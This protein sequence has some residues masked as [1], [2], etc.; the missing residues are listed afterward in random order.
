MI[1]IATIA[2]AIEREREGALPGRAHLVDAAWHTLMWLISREH[3]G[4][5][6]KKNGG[7][8]PTISIRR[9]AAILVRC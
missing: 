9:R 1:S 3:A 5:P 6:K 8:T 2:E 4:R 7:G